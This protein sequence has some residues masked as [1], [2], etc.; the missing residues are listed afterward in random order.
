VRTLWECL[1]R[2]DYDPIEPLVDPAFVNHVDG[3]EGFEP[4]KAIFTRATDAFPDLRWEVVA[5]LGDGD[6]VAVVATGRG[7]HTGADYR[8]VS[9]AGASFTWETMHLYRMRDGRI[10]D[11]SAV[12][13]DLAFVEQLRAGRP[14]AAG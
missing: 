5:L 6:E 14:A 9:A 2:H 1:D 7:T 11:H 3:N 10:L 12:R 4:W 13:N 8:G